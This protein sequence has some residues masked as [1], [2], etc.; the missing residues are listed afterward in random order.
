MRNQIH[1]EH[2][3][4]K[5]SGFFRRL[6]NFHAAAFAAAAGM[7]LRFHYDAGRAI[8]EKAPGLHQARLRGF[9]PSGRAAQLLHTSREWPFPGTH[10]FSF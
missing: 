10:V 2:L 6:G 8:L 9:R 3:G 7:N 4:G 1:A 5:F